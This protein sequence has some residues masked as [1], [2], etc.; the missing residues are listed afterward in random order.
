M[1]WERYEDKKGH[2]FL[3]RELPTGEVFSV[4]GWKNA[5]KDRIMELGKRDFIGD[6]IKKVRKDLE[7]DGFHFVGLADGKPIQEKMYKQTVDNIKQGKK[8]V[9]ENEDD[10]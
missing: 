4:Y 9:R 6:N 7:E 5:F 3:L 2:Y 8:Y 1:S 10:D